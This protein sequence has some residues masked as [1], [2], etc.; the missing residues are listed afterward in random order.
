M[1]QS[2]RPIET[3]PHDT[4]EERPSCCGA[5]NRAAG[6]RACGSRSMG[7]FDH[8]EEP[9]SP[10]SLDGNSVQAADAAFRAGGSETSLGI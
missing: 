7:G 6:R 1:W 5:R 4:A 3:A 9:F 2:A 8:A 10:D